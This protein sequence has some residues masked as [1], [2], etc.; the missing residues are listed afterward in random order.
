MNDYYKVLLTIW[1]N[2]I[3][4]AYLKN[5][6]PVELMV[7]QNKKEQLGSIYL[8]RVN[9]IVSNIDAAFV[10]YAKNT[11]GFLKN[12]G[13][14]EGDLVPVQLVKE[15]TELKKAALS[16]ELSI[17][18]IYSV[19]HIKDRNLS[20][21]SKIDEDKRKELKKLFEKAP[22]ET[23]FGIILRT[24]A[25]D[26]QYDIIKAEID[27]LSAILSDIIKFKDKRIALSVLYRSEAEWLT[28]LNSINID[29]LD[30]IITDDKEIYQDILDSFS[31]K[32]DND[33]Q[34]KVDIKFYQD[35][36]LPLKSLY[37]LNKHL[38]D[39]TNR[40][41][42]L[43]SG[44]FIVIEPTEALVSIDINTGKITKKQ[45]TEE[46]FLQVNMEAC[47]EIARQLR[48]RNLSGII[49]IDFIN[50]KD[51]SNSKLLIEHLREA[52]KDD[53]LKAKVHDMT[54]LGLVEVTR[55]KGRRPLYEQS[56]ALTHDAKICRNK[57]NI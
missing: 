45:S 16:E 15:A 27:K 31:T 26:A 17:S 21:S 50:L 56:R 34:R 55:M 29:H 24:N 44:A 32:Y 30:E 2:C 35:D 14:K 19:V 8:G 46:T 53:P 38:T 47:D 52:L 12:N 39:A 49:I 20:V 28:A 9:K 54:R 23:G 18:G 33:S 40:I 3:F 6:K 13:Y 5:D 7:F 25:K 41:V 57:G 22:N 11:S 37:N 48:L 4:F 51:S 43:K 42:W 10:T 1:N 36:L